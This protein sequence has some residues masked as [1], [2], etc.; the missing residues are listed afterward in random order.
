MESILEMLW[1]RE[2]D[3]ELDQI[4]VRKNHPLKGWKEI[5]FRKGSAALVFII[6][7]AT[8]IRSVALDYPKSG[9]Y[10]TGTLLCHFTL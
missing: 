8:H 7:C 10:F 3:R 2:D 6:F 9:F 1:S 5:A 4:G